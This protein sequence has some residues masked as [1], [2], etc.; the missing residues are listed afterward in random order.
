LL[1]LRILDPDLSSG[2]GKELA[3]FNIAILLLGFHVLMLMAP[4]LPSYS[5]G[6]VVG[7]YAATFA[8]G[9]VALVVLARRLSAAVVTAGAPEPE[10]PRSRG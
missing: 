6:S 1:L 5:L 9:A 4:I 8:V 7:V 2:I 10:D 3:F